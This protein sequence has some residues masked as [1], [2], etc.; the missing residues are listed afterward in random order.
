[1]VSKY[2]SIFNNYIL[3]HNYLGYK[4]NLKYSLLNNFL[5]KID[6]TIHFNTRLKNI[7]NNMSLY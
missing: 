1:L 2:S 3:M 6:M 5:N 7:I 4:L